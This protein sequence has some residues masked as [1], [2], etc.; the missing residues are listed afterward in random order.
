M[1]QINNAVGYTGKVNIRLSTS[2]QPIAQLNNAGFKPLWDALSMAIVGYDISNRRPQYFMVGKKVPSGNG[3]VYQDCL[4]SKIPFLGAVWGDVVEMSETS[5]SARFTATV[6]SIDRAIKITSGET[7]VLRMY[8][9]SGN[10]LA[11]VEDQDEKIAK[12]HNGMITGVDAIYE[13]IMTFKNVTA[14][15]TPS[16]SESEGT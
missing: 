13:W 9:V 1:N 6:A 12:S 2:K 3:L 11:E 5:T 15:S 4:L 7:A 14:S 8:D 10:L 16:Q